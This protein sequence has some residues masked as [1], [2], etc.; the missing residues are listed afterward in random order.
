MPISDEIHLRHLTVDE[1]MLKLDRYIHD[2]YIAGFSRVRVVH[3]KGAGTLRVLVDRMLAVHPLVT[4]YRRGI[5]GE[6]GDG[7]TVVELSSK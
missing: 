3:G 2:A 1:A 7:V 5:R 6:G 4:S